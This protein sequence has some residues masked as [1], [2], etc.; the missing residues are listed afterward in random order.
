MIYLNIL[1]VLATNTVRSP[2]K[3]ETSARYTEGSLLSR[4]A[5]PPLDGTVQTSPALMNARCWLSLDQL[6]SD[7]ADGLAVRV[8][9]SPPLTDRKTTCPR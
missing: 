4:F 6:S 9:T 1:K 8:R 2:A 7:F 3:V 5:S